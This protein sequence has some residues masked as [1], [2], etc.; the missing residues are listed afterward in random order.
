MSRDE[1][2]LVD[3]LNAAQA[4]QRFVAGMTQEQF[5]GDEKT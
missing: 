4:A 3:I 5:S 1:A 2:A